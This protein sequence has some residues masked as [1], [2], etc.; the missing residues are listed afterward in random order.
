MK[1]I[2]VIFFALIFSLP[3]EARRGGG[4]V[5]GDGVSRNDIINLNQIVDTDQRDLK[6]GFCYEYFHFFFLDITTGGGE[7]C[8]Y[9]NSDQHR[10]LSDSDAA[11]ILAVSEDELPTPFLYRYPL[12]WVVL[13]VVF[14]FPMTIMVLAL[15]TES[16]R[17]T[18]KREESK[19]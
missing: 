12:L 9:S 13:G 3:A 19:A 14:G 6:I 7:Y 2:I 15:I 17:N 10:S 11:M 4:C 16:I 5:F 8:L 18:N 1:Y